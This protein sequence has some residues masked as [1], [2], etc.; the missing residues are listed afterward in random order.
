MTKVK[1]DM[2]HPEFQQKLYKL[3]KD[4]RHALI[5]TFQKLSDMTWDQVY[6]DKGLR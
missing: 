6:S 2:N 3:D 1:I 5:N 4:Q